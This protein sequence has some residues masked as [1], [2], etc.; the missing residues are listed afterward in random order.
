MADLLKADVV[1]ISF[2]WRWVEPYK[3]QYHWGH[4][5]KMYRAYLARGIRP[6]FTILFAPWW[7]WDPSVS[8]NQWRENCKYPPGRAHDGEWREIAALLAA[9]Y[10][11]AAGIEIWNEPN[12]HWFWAPRPDPARYTELQKAAYEAIKAVN[13]AMPVVNGGLLSVGRTNALGL[14]AHDFLAEIYRHGGRDSM[15]AINLHPY[16]VGL[17][18]RYFLNTFAKVRSVRDANKDAR[19][20]LWVTEFGFTTTG[21][22]PRYMVTPEEQ[23]LGLV[24][25]YRAMRVMRDVDLL[26]L[27][28]LID[29]KG[30]GSVYDPRDPNV[31]YG[32]V[33][34]DLRPKPAFCALFRERRPSWTCPQ[35][36]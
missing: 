10:P 9:R 13:P 30:R 31:G 1:R 33:D 27:Y 3:D 5:D 28:T 26:A 32:L 14:T 2:G 19:K 34:P 21:T 24:D 20:P 36:P 35:G 22:D 17:D 6:V 16:P 4:Y 12:L 15:D 11:D 23:A 25:H 29:P 8:C 18:K 7:T